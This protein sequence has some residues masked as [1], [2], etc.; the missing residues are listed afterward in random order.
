[1]ES[2]ATIAVAIVAVLLYALGA[3]L[4]TAYFGFGAENKRQ[5]AF[6]LGVG[7]FWLPVAAI[8]LVCVLWFVLVDAWHR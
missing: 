5:F 3:V 8:L 6:T 7:V 1:M 4:V 2:A